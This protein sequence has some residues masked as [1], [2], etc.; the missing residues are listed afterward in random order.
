MSKHEM[1][2]LIGIITALLIIFNLIISIKISLELKKRSIDARLAHRRGII[3][4]YLKIY[5]RYKIEEN[6]NPGLLYYLFMIT[7]ILFMS[8]LFLGIILSST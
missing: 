1:T 2:I 5:K 3:F 6:G 7:F 4:K 8:F